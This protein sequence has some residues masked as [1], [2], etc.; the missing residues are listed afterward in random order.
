MLGIADEALSR[1]AAMSGPLNDL[2]G[3]A[4]IVMWNSGHFDT[5]DIADVLGVPEDAVWRLLHAA[6]SLRKGGAG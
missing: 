4:A 6:R 1:S 3:L 2:Q 5:K